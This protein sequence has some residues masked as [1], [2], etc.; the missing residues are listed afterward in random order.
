[1]GDGQHVTLALRD[2]GH[3]VTGNP[4]ARAVRQ[5]RQRRRRII[6]WAVALGALAA[7]VV[8]APRAL[9]KKPLLVKTVKVERLRVR[10]VVSSS[11]AGEVVPARKA[12]VRAEL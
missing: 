9:K 2:P 3:S 6:G 1:M 8:V 10:D 11:T 7:L 12:T 4:D 5:Q